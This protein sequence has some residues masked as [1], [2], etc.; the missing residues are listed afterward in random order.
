MAYEGKDFA[1]C[2]A[3]DRRSMQKAAEQLLGVATGLIADSSINDKEILFLQTWLFDHPELC[4]RW[5]GRPIA[6]RIRAI[7]SD[8]IITDAERTDMLELLRGICGYQFDETG[9]GE[10][11]VAAIPYD[12]DP[13]VWIEG[14]TFCLTGRFLFGNRA[15]CERAVLSRGGFIADSVTTKLDYLV[16]GSMVEPTWANTTYGRKIEKALDYNDKGHGIAIVPEKDWH[17]A[18]FL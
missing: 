1:A 4:H 12:D 11:S 14:Y 17:A 13:S 6:D 16:V 10:P 3:I 8:G 5:P 2:S 18:L 7:L 9:T 15:D